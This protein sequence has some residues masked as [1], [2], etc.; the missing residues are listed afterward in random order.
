MDDYLLVGIFCSTIAVILLAAGIILALFLGGRKNMQQKMLFSE[1]ELR[2]E[3]ELRQTENEISERMMERF[4]QELHDNIGHSLTCIRI[5]IENKKLDD[6]PLEKVFASIESYLNE[7]SNQ[8]R[9][10]S[11]SLNTD[12]ISNLGLTSAIDVEVERLRQLKRQ[13]VHYERQGDIRL[14]NDQELMAFR[15]F[16]EILHNALR[17]SKA[18]NIWV[19]LKG[20]D[21]FML[22]VSDDGLGFNVNTTLSSKK[23]SGLQNILKRA[24]MAGFR[25]TIHSN[26][27][28]G[29][30]INL[31]LNN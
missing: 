5:D 25:C 10:L 3:K 18:E 22:A 17:H 11:R 8:L 20:T 29:T 9:S 26:P 21:G 6:P 23:A 12:Y 13:L 30:R 15:I 16:Q 2:Y 24:Q 31:L 4:S 14:S 19:I 27:E 7:A 28:K 1:R